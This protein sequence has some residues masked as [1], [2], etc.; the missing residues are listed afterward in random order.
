MEQLFM[1]TSP[2]WIIEHTWPID[3][4]HDTDVE[5]RADAWFEV[6]DMKRDDFGSECGDDECDMCY[7]DHG[8]STIEYEG[9]REPIM[10]WHKGDAESSYV[11]AAWKGL[12]LAD[13]HHRLTM[14]ADVGLTFVPV[15]WVAHEAEAQS[16]WDDMTDTWLEAALMYAES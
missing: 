14:A 1:F 10:L 12:V 15:V 4:G 7:S 13:G 11:P 3:A 8:Y 5:D 16:R 9:V 2:T 6:M